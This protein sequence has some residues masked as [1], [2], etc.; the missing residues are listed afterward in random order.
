MERSLKKV[1]ITTFC[2]YLTAVVLLCFLKP[3][4]LPEMGIMTFLG[5]PID[6]CLHFMMFLPFPILAGLVFIEKERGFL[7]GVSIL[8]VLAVVGL[9]LSYGTEL[10][11]AHTTNINMAIYHFFVFTLQR[12]N[13]FRIYA[14]A[15]IIFIIFINKFAYSKKK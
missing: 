15:Y 10:I 9:G 1:Y 4:S 11:Q 2:I 8:A 5:I 13:F 7:S 14:S 6:K 3:S 12:Y